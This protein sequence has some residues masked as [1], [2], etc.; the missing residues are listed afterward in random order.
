MLSILS[1]YTHRQHQLSVHFLLTLPSQFCYLNNPLS[2]HHP[3]S[4][5]FHHYTH[6]LLNTVLLISQRAPCIL[7]LSFYVHYLISLS[8]PAYRNLSLTFLINYYFNTLPGI[9]GQRVNSNPLIPASSIT[10]HK[11]TLMAGAT[12]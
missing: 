3:K 2:L 7:Y 4:V 9:S 11:F 10:A 12:R 6:N 8:S 5:Y 1:I